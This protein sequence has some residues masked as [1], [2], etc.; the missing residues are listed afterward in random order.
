MPTVPVRVSVSNL[1]LLLLLGM[2]ALLF[3][4][5]VWHFSLNVPLTDDWLLV[6]TLTRVIDPATPWPEALRLLT[7]QHIDHRILGARLLILAD[8]VAE[9][10]LNLRTLLVGGSVCVAGFVWLLHRFFRQANRALWAI[11]PVA[12]LLFQP[13]YQ[14][15]VWWLICLLQH[16]LTLFL[17]L[18]L[19]S[20]I[21]R[22]GTLAQVGML[23]LAALL[24]YS[25]TNGLFVWVAMLGLHLLR[26][27]WGRAAV[28]AAV[29][30]VVFGLYFWLDYSFRSK[31]AALALWQHPAW[32]LNGLVGFVGGG[33][34][35]EG[36]RWLGVPSAWAVVG[37]GVSILGLMAISGWRAVFG[38]KKPSASLLAL[39][40]LS[41]VLVC[42]G[43]A[44]AVARGT[45]GLLVVGRY[46]IFAVLC[47][48]VA[49]ALLVLQLTN[50]RHQRLVVAGATGLA[51][52]FWLNA[53]L[54][55]G[56]A[57]AHRHNALLADALNLRTYGR[58]VTSQAFLA[59][60]FW[61]NLLQ[62]T[63][64]RG[65]YAVPDFPQTAGL[66]QALKQ[67][68]TSADVIFRVDSAF[69]N[70][71][72]VPMQTISHDTLPTPTYLCLWSAQHAYL[73]PATPPPASFLKPLGTGRGV[74]SAVMPTLLLPGQYRIG[75]VR[76]DPTGRWRVT[77]S[78]QRIWGG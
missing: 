28:W 74:T 33:V 70:V 72:Y 21:D 60:P 68:P 37:A 29:G 13:S 24:V 14:E 46:Q 56:P 23:G 18:Y 44:A 17:S 25:N 73:L 77:C 49:Y 11:L 67:T 32:V 61:Q 16:T 54:L 63:R 2:L 71:H 53:W 75:W 69:S 8:Y 66:V 34:A 65:I 78:G 31:G 1:L 64:E 36:R 22:P 62:Q 30:A 27:R 45:G 59:V 58:S 42:T 15:D 43:G 10:H 35:F 51:G 40:A 50:P 4:A 76:K 12:L 39:L 7:E 41:F 3:Y 19:F 20:Q 47:L 55:Y 38:Q 5:A 57:L 48:V 6:F 52:W 9:G 26:R